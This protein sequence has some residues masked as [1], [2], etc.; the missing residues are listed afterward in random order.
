LR[1][2]LLEYGYKG[3]PVY[4]FNGLALVFAFTIFRLII[5]TPVLLKMVYE[6]HTLPEKERHGIPMRAI[7]TLAPLAMVV[8]NS[9]WGLAL[10]K[11]L[12]K[13]LGFAGSK[14]DKNKLS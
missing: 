12:F 10:W 3:S 9:F 13:A 14:K 11:G 5:G 1:W 7:F 2:W 6:L 8:L 4:A